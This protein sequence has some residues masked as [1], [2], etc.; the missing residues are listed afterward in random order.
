MVGFSRETRYLSYN[1]ADL[2][3]YFSSTMMGEKCTSDLFAFVA[4]A[5]AGEVCF[6]GVGGFVGEM[7]DDWSEQWAVSSDAW[8]EFGYHILC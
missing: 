6:A 3:L 7:V 4:C 5:A 8:E 2:S 1:A